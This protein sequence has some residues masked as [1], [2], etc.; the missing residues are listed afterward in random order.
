MVGVN[1]FGKKA[2]GNAIVVPRYVQCGGEDDNSSNLERFLE[3]SYILNRNSFGIMSK[4]NP[5]RKC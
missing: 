1:P 5:N 2:K 4:E 3:L